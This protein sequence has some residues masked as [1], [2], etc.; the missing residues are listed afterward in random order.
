MISFTKAGTKPSIMTALNFIQPQDFLGDVWLVNLK[1]F[2][3][4]PLPNDL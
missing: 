1:T 3:F 2:N 4:I